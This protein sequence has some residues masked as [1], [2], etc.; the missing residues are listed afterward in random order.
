MLN[1]QEDELKKM[2]AGTVE[3]EEG[4]ISENEESK[5]ND[6]P[7]ETVIKET[8]LASKPRRSSSFIDVPQEFAPPPNTQQILFDTPGNDEQMSQPVSTL[9][10]KKRNKAD[11][12]ISTDED[13]REVEKKRIIKIQQENEIHNLRISQAAKA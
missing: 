6:I 4:E 11:A 13:L 8:R 10:Q 12:N 2:K 7:M 3:V 5:S 9:F 1:R